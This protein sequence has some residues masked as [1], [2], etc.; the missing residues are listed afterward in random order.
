MVKK[1]FFMAAAVAVAVTG[2]LASN[3]AAHADAPITP[4]DPELVD[5]QFNNERGRV[6][7]SAEKLEAERKILGAP[8]P[9]PRKIAP[10]DLPLNESDRAT[11][12]SG[13]AGLLAA[14]VWCGNW[15]SDPNAVTLTDVSYGGLSL[16][17]W[18]A[19]TGNVNDDLWWQPVMA[20]SASNGIRYG[21]SKIY[22]VVHST[23]RFLINS[24]VT[25]GW[26]D[27]SS[28]PHFCGWGS[29]LARTV[30]SEAAAYTAGVRQTEATYIRGHGKPNYSGT[31]WLYPSTKTAF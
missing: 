26:W 12:R 11:A 20:T 3:V 27:N 1:T 6:Q 30:S 28:N 15:L 14:D 2:V 5:P 21:W 25:T 7:V 24:Q 4:G 16:Y 31:G 23:G 18:R 9:A 10:E 13:D 22:D 17:T 8:A 19:P 29:S